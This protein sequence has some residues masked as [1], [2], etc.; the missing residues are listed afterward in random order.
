M[1]AEAQEELTDAEM[2]EDPE[3]AGPDVE[4]DFIGKLDVEDSL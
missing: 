4:M 3:A 2:A 1:G